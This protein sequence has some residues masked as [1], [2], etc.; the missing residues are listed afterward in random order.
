MITGLSA[1]GHKVR[2]AT[3]GEALDQELRADSAD[4]VVLDIG[5]GDGCED[6]FAIAARLRRSVR[7]AI[8]MVTAKNELDARIRGLESGADAYMVKPFDFC[9]LS[10]VM[11]SVMR[12]LRS[13]EYE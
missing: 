7:C 3:D 10:A 9:E 4:I 5:L 8:I 1:L 13:V 6:G 12:R 11:S 2:G